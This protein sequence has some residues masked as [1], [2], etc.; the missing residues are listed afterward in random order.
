[1]NSFQ[2]K[3]QSLIFLK[4]A[5]LKI[6]PWKVISHQEIIS[7]GD[8][9]ILHSLQRLISEKQ[10][11]LIPI[12]AMGF[13]STIKV[14]APIMELERAQHAWAVRS[15]AS[16]EDQ[17]AHSFAGIFETCLQVKDDLE[18]S[19]Q[20]VWSSLYTELCLNYCDHLNLSWE[21]LK[22]D[23][24]LQEMIP[25][26][27]T[28]IIFQGP[29][30]I[31]N[32]HDHQYQIAGSDIIETDLGFSPQVLNQA[33]IEKVLMGSNKLK[34]LVSTPMD[35]EFILQEN[36]IFFL[37]ARPVRVAPPLSKIKVNL[38]QIKGIPAAIGEASAECS[39]PG[40]FG[41]SVTDKILVLTSHHEAYE[42]F[43]KGIKG[44]IL[45]DGNLLS[46]SSIMA[47]ELGIPCIIK[48]KNAT[49]ILKS[50]MQL[51]M[52]GSSGLIEVL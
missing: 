17:S 42:Y 5:G 36:E 37:Q 19:I 25:G 47:R 23:I 45:E 41:N 35:L 43:F 33:E 15:S 1:M 52:S 18:E 46:H 50:G 24:I 2:G 39:I 4:S 30:D 26:Q 38:D 20:K 3:A 6:P 11:K 32:T 22:M 10:K 51:K 48:V 9:Q 16:V 28:G 21:N 14:P 49:Q 31:I 29:V 34:A 44:L 12:H 27:K 7:W 13:A 8:P 40:T